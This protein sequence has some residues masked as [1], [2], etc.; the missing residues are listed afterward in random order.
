MSNLKRPRATDWGQDNFDWPQGKR[1][2]YEPAHHGYNY[3]GQNSWQPLPEIYETVYD[4]QASIP[5]TVPAIMHL[6]DD[7]VLSARG[8]SQGPQ[9]FDSRLYETDNEMTFLSSQQSG[10]SLAVEGSQNSFIFD[11]DLSTILS[12]NIP[13]LSPIETSDASP[14]TIDICYGSVSL[15][16]S[17]VSELT[18]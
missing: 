4:T 13:V 17:S 14:K 5:N 7:S 1:M 11:G 16:S 3:G 10:P 12:T 9:Y 15:Q 2:V 8:L 6:S 18:C